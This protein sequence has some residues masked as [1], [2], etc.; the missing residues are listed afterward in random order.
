MEPILHIL[1]PLLIL[2]ALFPKLDKRLVVG[3]SLL[4]ILPDFDFFIPPLHRV[5]THNV[6]FALIISLI[7][8]AIWNN[9]K[10][11]YISLYYL[12]THLILDLTIGAVALFYPFYKRLIEI[13]ISLSTNW[14]PTINIRTYELSKVLE[15]T[16]PHY[17]FTK[18]S[19]MVLLILIV[20]LVIKYRKKL[21]NYKWVSFFVNR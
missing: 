13:N 16:G 14:V 12:L 3:L 8:Y 4:A 19:V 5:I 6:F 18:V 9:I 7:I 15:Y 11:F 2:L 1:I 17:F 10:I 20:M 21:F